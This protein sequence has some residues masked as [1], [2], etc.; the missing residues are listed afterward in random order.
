MNLRCV[1]DDSEE[2]T[3][4]ASGKLINDDGLMLKNDANYSSMI[5][6]LSFSTG[7]FKDGEKT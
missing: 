6:D 3:C 7:P 4:T 1:A 5:F 2:N